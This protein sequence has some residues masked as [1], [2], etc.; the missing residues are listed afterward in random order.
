VGVSPKA[1]Y[2][3][4]ISWKYLSRWVGIPS[5]EGAPLLPRKGIR[6]GVAMIMIGSGRGVREDGCGKVGG[7]GRLCGIGAV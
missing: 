3:L 1:A 4:S 7:D 6:P 5:N 2:I